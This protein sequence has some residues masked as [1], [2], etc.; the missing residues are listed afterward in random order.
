MSKSF[1]T[2]HKNLIR[3]AWSKPLLQFLHRKLGG[4]LVYLGLPGPEIEDLDEWLEHL[5]HIIAFQCEDSRY[6]N[7]FENLRAKLQLLERERR[8][9][10]Y[11]VYKGYIEQVLLRGYDE[12]EERQS[13]F[14]PDIVTVYNLDFCNKITSPITFKDTDGEI[15]KAYKFEAVNCLLDIQRNLNEVSKKFIL[16]LTVHCSYDGNELELFIRNPPSPDIS[17]YLE[18][19]RKVKGDMKNACIIRLFIIETLQAY[20]RTFGFVPKF[21]PTLFYR[22]LKQTP[23]LHFTIMGCTAQSAA[24][25]TPW[26]QSTPSLITE[27]FLTIEEEN[28]TNLHSEMIEKEIALVD[29]VMHFS[30]S[31]TYN[32]FWKSA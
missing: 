2:P 25:T 16:F 11:Q 7:A 24:G 15:K 28:F 21:L 18:N 8:I 32:R 29:P 27:K 9:D 17:T 3:V 10:N 19:S 31:A 23:L 6:P 30:Q 22:G 4:R 1:T 12:A 14:Q 13:F 26:L 5:R 20:F